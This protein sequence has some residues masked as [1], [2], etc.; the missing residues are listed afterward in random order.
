MTNR[1]P[2][3]QPDLIEYTG[4]RLDFVWR[5][6]FKMFGAVGEIKFEAR[7]LLSTDY[8]E[9]QQLNN[10]TILNNSYEIGR[11]FQLS[12]SLQF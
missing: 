6:G 3:G 7:N 8:V 2:S 12:A 5:E 9:F 1:G 4:A 11:S 10:S